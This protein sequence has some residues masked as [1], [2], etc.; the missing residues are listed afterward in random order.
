MVTSL[1][2][3]PTQYIYEPSKAPLSVQQKTGAII[4]KNYPPPLVDHSSVSKANMSRM[5]Q[6]YDAA[7]NNTNNNLNVPNAAAEV[8]SEDNSDH[9]GDMPSSLPSRVRNHTSATAD[10]GNSRKRAKPGK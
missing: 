8:A 2:K 6:A 3:F 7:N 1:P 9:S 4:G 10:S 5:K